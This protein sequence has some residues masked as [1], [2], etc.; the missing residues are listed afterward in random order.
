MKDKTSWA[1]TH[2]EVVCCIQEALTDPESIASKRMNEQ[3]TGGMWEL[4][5]EITDSFEEKYADREWESDWFDTLYP[6][7]NERIF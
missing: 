4:A 5:Q 1:E 3:G 2:Y 7:V 6:F